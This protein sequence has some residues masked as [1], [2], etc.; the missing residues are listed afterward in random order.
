[1]APAQGPKS[2]R[3]PRNLN[4]TTI[5]A[6]ILLCIVTGI[7]TLWSIATDSSHPLR[8]DALNALTDVIYRSQP[9]ALV[10]ISKDEFFSEF[11]VS[12]YM[13]FTKS[14]SIQMDRLM[15]RLEDQI[16]TDS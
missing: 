5:I 13:H 15:R 2:S 6:Q 12:R 1:M 14:Y 10:I 11:V 16:S 8:E 3:C 9:D 7:D 4:D